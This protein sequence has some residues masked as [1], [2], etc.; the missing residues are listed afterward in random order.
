MKKRCASVILAAALIFALLSGCGTSPQPET[1]EPAVEATVI[2]A[3]LDQAGSGYYPGEC[4]AEG[5]EILDI[6]R[7]E[8]Q[9][10]VYL[11][12]SV[13]QY[14][15]C[16]GHFEEISGS[17][18]IPTRITFAEENGALVV[19]DHWQPEDGS[20]YADSIKETFPLS[21]QL[22]ALSAQ[23][24]YDGLKEQKQAYAEAY[25]ESIG[26]EAPVGA[27]GDF[28]HPLFT[29]LGMS[30][31]VSNELLTIEKLYNFPFYIGNVERVEDGVRWIYETAWNSPGD[32]TG[33]AIY[34]KKN[35]ETGEVDQQYAYLVDGDRCQEAVPQGPGPNAPA[36]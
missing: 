22:Q 25:L 9:W 17:G 6:V 18:A 29:D 15:F 36:D 35:Y 11:I 10:Q 19:E 30:V 21:L 7:E 8:D 31:A 26:R 33:T 32:G 34:T 12:A 2:S 24:Y 4:V 28:D 16:T 23:D 13:G 5:H 1:G 14:G 20:G 3:L 27:Y